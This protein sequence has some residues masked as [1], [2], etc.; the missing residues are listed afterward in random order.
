MGRLFLGP[1]VG[2]WPLY[3]LYLFP[4]AVLNWVCGNVVN[5]CKSY[6]IINKI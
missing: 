4:N 3:S 6:G 2:F 1:I 5:D